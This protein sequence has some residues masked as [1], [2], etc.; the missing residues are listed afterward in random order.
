MVNRVFSHLSCRY[1]NKTHLRYLSSTHRCEHLEGNG[2][3]FLYSSSN[4]NILTYEYL[5]NSGVSKNNN[6][7]ASYFEQSVRTSSPIVIFM[8]VFIGKNIKENQNPV[9]LLL[10]TNCS[11]ELMLENKFSAKEDSSNS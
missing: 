4:L 3:I 11:I 9:D 2:Q 8:N 1:I 10:K 6:K 5:E 7:H